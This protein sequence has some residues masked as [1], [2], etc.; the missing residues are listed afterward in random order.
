MKPDASKVEAEQKQRDEMEGL[1]RRVACTCLGS[2]SAFYCYCPLARSHVYD[3]LRVCGS[4]GKVAQ[5]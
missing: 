3:L 2:S 5:D 4:L 1:R